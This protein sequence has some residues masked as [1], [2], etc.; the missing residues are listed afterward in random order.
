MYACASQVVEERWYAYYTN[1]S[2]LSNVTTYAPALYA[3]HLE[4]ASDTSFYEA[5]TNFT[6]R[7]ISYETSYFNKPNNA[8]CISETVRAPP[9]SNLIYSVESVTV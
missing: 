8:T 4:G 9:Y 2:S 7:S 5:F 3:K 1:L 6:D